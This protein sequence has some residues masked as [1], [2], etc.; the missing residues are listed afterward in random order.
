MIWQDAVSLGRKERE[1]LTMKVEQALGFQG[2]FW[3]V[4]TS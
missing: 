1:I 3:S 2:G 4:G